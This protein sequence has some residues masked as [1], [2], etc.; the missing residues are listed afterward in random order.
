MKVSIQGHTD[1]IG[2]REANQNL[3]ENRAKSV[4]E[5]LIKLGVNINRISYKG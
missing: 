2:N 5:Y 4:F 1:N 3:S